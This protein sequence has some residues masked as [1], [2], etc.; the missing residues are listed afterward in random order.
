[1]KKIAIIAA[2]LLTSGPALAGDITGEWKR[3]D[4]RSRIRMAPC[5]GGVCG[6]ITWLRDSNS[7]AQVGQQVFYGLR[8]SGGGWE[9]SAYNPE[10]GRTY[11][12]KVTVSGR[13]MTTRGC[14][15]GGVICKSVNWTRL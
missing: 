4:G 15:F 8:P 12:G 14:A 1:M 6:T 13:G 7:P 5:G 3:T 2:A 11:E 9:G 10:D